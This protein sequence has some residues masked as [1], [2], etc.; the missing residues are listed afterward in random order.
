MF[1]RIARLALLFASTLLTAF[2]LACG[3]GGAENG[4]AD[5]P[6][7]AEPSPPADTD[8]IRDV[9][10]LQVP[11]LANV[12]GQIGGGDPDI[13]SVKYADV[14]GDQRDEAILPITSGGT[15][16]NLAYLVLTMRSG[17][18]AVILTALRDRQSLGGI[19]IN[20]EDGKVVKY[21]G[22]YGPEDPRCCPSLLVKT[23]YRWDG[24]NLQVEREEEVPA[25][26]P[27]Q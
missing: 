10:L 27:K 18:P 19:T 6:P 4:D 22:K 25:G 26:T 21:T 24:A 14:T 3:S 5:A 17:H 2:V 12:I 16:G 11:A 7:T 8:A 9:N 23:S 20:V 13:A 1:S 15:L